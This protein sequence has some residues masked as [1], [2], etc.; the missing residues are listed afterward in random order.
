MDNLRFRII[1][2]LTEAK[3]MWDLF[4]PNQ[5]IDDDWSFRY[6]FIHNLDLPLHFIVGHINEEPIGLLPLQYNTLKGLSPKLLNQTQPYFEFF[7]GVDTDDNRIFFK[8]GFEYLKNDFLAQ[9]KLPAVLT[10]LKEEYSFQNQK[11]EYYLDRYELAL[12]NIHNFD[13]YIDQNFSGKTRRTIK[14]ELRNRLKADKVEVVDGD[15]ADLELLFSYSIA[16]FGEKSS[17]N[18]PQRRQIY[19]DLTK[20]FAVDIFK[21]VI[22]GHTKAV[23]YGIVHNKV[24][25]GLNMGYDYSVPGLGKFLITSTLPRAINHGCDKYDTGQGD[26]GWK[27][28]LHLKKIPQYILKLNNAY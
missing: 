9:I 26:N 17:F 11:S 10:S 4:S 24:F 15:L 21:V 6:T 18:M 14:H 27:E 13:D 16:R 19:R 12:Q 5:T 28:K 2:D 8:S 22:D 25:T 23:G 3:T 1:S 20:K 7:G